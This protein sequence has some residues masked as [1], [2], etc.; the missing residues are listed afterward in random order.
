MDV[1]S[2]GAVIQK[3]IE[4]WKFDPWFAVEEASLYEAFVPDQL[5]S[6]H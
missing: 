2:G 3:R 5:P 4:S 1:E 6:Q